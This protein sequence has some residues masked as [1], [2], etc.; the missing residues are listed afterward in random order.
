MA[1]LAVMISFSAAVIGAF[2]LSA[3]HGLNVGQGLALYSC[4]G[5]SMMT[6][7]LMTYGLIDD[8]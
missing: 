1:L 5:L 7:V 3:M 4:L 6:V 8:S 2:S